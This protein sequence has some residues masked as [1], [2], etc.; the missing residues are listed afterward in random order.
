MSVGGA[1]R[2]RNQRRAAR[3]QTQ[4]RTKREIRL[5]DVL[6]N[7][8]V[9]KLRGQL[10]TTSHKKLLEALAARAAC[11]KPGYR[12][13]EDRQDEQLLSIDVDETQT[14][15]L[16]TSSSDDVPSRPVP[17]S[18]AEATWTWTAKELQEISRVNHYLLKVHGIAPGRKG[19]RITRLILENANGINSRITNNDKLDKARQLIDDLEADLVAIT[20]TVR[21]F[22][23]KSIGMAFASSSTAAKQISE[24]WLRITLM[25]M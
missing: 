18:V 1:R 20:N 24:Q 8:N 14:V 11:F 19:D 13:W 10:Q 22:G 7:V 2:T 9:I 25:K 6:G 17:R 3:F 21:T 5:I 4:Q 16:P 15:L 12:S 23:I